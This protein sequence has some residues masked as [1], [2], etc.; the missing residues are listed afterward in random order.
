MAEPTALRTNNEAPKNNRPRILAVIECIDAAYEQ[1]V[2]AN[3]ILGSVMLEIEKGADWMVKFRD[4]L[5]TAVEATGGD[6]TQAVEGQ[7]RDFIGNKKYQQPQ[8]EGH[9]NG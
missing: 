4:G 1:M 9:S 7:I 6:V 5:V 2:N 3:R 8:T